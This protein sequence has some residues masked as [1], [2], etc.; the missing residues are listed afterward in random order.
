M[1]AWKSIHLK[2][3]GARIS[4]RT[5]CIMSLLVTSGPS[6]R[7]QR[8]FWDQSDFRKAYVMQ[9]YSC[10]T[11]MVVI[12]SMKP[13]FTDILVDCTIYRKKCVNRT[14]MVIQGTCLARWPPTV[15]TA[16][17]LDS[18]LESTSFKSSPLLSLH[19]KTIIRMLRHTQNHPSLPFAK[20]T[21]EFHDCL[22]PSDVH[23]QILGS[24]LRLDRHGVFTLIL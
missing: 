6:H 10:S 14:N 9:R 16:P 1:A 21:R 20:D 3:S 24:H 17:S 18:Y 4:R 13:L 5:T 22:F 15:H 8:L 2:V 7:H 12:D 19:Y 11:N 23:Y